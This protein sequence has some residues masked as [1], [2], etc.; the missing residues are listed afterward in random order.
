[1]GFDIQTVLLVLLANVFATAIALP[2][3]MGWRVSAAARLFQV[4]V[5][6]HAFGWLAFLLA[7]RVH[8]RLLTSLAIALMSLSFALLWSALDAWLGGRPGRHAIWALVALTPLGYALAYD[9]YPWRVGW[10]NAGLALQ[11]LIV[12]AALAWPAPQAS[13]RWRGLVLACMGA[14]A[15]AT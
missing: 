11:M 1:M 12:C 7:P 8:D 13:R 4:G 6:V 9:N 14:L 15:V 10:S 2:L 5:V 3:L